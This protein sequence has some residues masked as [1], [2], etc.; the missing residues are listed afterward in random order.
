MARSRHWEPASHSQ[1]RRRKPASCFPPG[2]RGCCLRCQLITR[3]Q[4]C[5]L[6][7]FDWITMAATSYWSTRQTDSG[8]SASDLLGSNNEFL[9]AI[10]TGAFVVIVTRRLSRT[11][12]QLPAPQVGQLR[13]AGS[14]RHASDVMGFAA[15]ERKCHASN[16]AKIW[17]FKNRKLPV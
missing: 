3:V 16:R 10:G 12:S 14:S 5:Y 6:T 13:I 1:Y 9:R 2:P 15:Q 4:A 7:A 8:Q 17:L 11:I